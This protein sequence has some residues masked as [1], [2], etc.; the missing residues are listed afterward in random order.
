MGGL[1]KELS[2]I[3]KEYKLFP[4]PREVDGMPYKQTLTFQEA[5]VL[6]PYPLKMNEGSYL[7]RRTLILLKDCVFPSTIE[8]IRGYYQA[9]HKQGG[10]QMT[11]L[12]PLEVTGGSYRTWCGW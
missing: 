6:F 5:Q 1:N 10:H 7:R 4:S 11:V 3:G 12:S 2:N 8:V 9:K